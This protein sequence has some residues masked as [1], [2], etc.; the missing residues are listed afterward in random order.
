V[1]ILEY[2]LRHQGQIVTREMLERDVWKQTRRFTSLDNVIDVQM[3]RLRRKIEMN[4]R[5]PLI[6]TLRGIGYRLGGRGA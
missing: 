6:H 3:M 2:L 5:P 4:S 1:D